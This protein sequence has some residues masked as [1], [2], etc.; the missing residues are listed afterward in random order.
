MKKP[1]F[2]IIIPTYNRANEIARCIDSIVAQSYKD[3]E[4]II[5]DN[6]STDNTE[7]IVLSYNDDRIHFYKNHNYGVISVSRNFGLDKSTGEWICFLDSDDSW[8]PTKL[9]QIFPYTN[10]YD[11]IYHGFISNGK[12]HGLIPTNK[13]IYYSIKEPTVAYLLQRSD[14]INTSSSAV[15]RSF[16][17][18][19]RFSEDKELFAIEDYDFFL[20][21]MKKHPRT[22]RLRKYLTYYDYSTGVSHINEE[23][24]ARNRRLFNKYKEELTEKE[25]RNVLKLYMKMKGTDLL[26]TDS[27]KSR[28]Y[29]YISLSSSVLLVKFQSLKAILHSYF[30][31]LKSYLFR[32]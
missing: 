29:F 15:K 28:R 6:Y 25:F 12:K 24:R 7:Q 32:N 2:S 1:F 26:F 27:A 31:Q 18:D 20:Q 13:V 8:A 22:I 19:T 21:L 10:K 9:E 11:L 16:I 3:W 5:I 4:A 23:I 14:P 30:I 17:G